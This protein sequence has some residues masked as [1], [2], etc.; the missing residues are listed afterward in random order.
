MV[1]GLDG[2]DAFGDLGTRKW[3]I[4]L[5]GGVFVLAGWAGNVAGDG[6]VR[7]AVLQGPYQADLTYSNGRKTWTHK[8]YS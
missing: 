5:G 6:G 7:S 2:G 3:R 8:L 1:D 4:S